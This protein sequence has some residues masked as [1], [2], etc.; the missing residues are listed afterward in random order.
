[1]N[2]LGR[3]AVVLVASMF[4]LAGFGPSSRQSERVA[5]ASAQGLGRE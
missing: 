5:G 3:I 4:F 2:L 1:M